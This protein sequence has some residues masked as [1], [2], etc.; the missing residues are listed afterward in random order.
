MTPTEIFYVTIGLASIVVVFWVNR[1][2]FGATRVPVSTAE[3][4]YYLV[5]LAALLCGWYFNFAYFRQYGSDAGWL[6]WT[7][8]L[9]VN[10]ASASGAQDLIIA[11]VILFP[12]WMVLDGRRNGVRIAWWYF[13]MSL[14]TSY[15]FAYAL[16]LAVQD[17]Q[18]RANVLRA[19]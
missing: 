14:I 2:L 8:L 19:Q 3:G 17:R 9:F 4:V 13:V 16:Y 18:L 5:G 7:K 12:M 11:N 15:A 1:D 6:H 10:P